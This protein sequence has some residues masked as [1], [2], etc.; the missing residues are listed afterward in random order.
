MVRLRVNL[1]RL[2]HSTRKT[3]FDDANPTLRKP[4]STPGDGVRVDLASRVALRG[5]RLRTRSDGASC[6]V[7]QDSRKYVAVSEGR[8]LRHIIVIAPRV[9][10]I[11]R[12][13]T[14]ITFQSSIQMTWLNH[15]P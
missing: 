14:L 15:M 4:Y 9:M 3:R 5:Q 8:A 13:S 10:N 1:L 7:W 12:K 2:K 11:Q 6:T